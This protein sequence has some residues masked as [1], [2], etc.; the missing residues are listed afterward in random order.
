[1][2]LILCG[3][4]KSGKTT[5]GKALAEVLHCPFVDVD[6]VI[7]RMDGEELSCREICK[8]RGENFF[9]ALEKN[10]L[11]SLQEVQGSVI[12]LGGGSCLETMHNLGTLIYLKVPVDTLWERA[13]QG[14]LP[15]YLDPHFPKESFYALAKK[16]FPLYEKAADLIIDV[17]LE[18]PTP[19]EVILSA[20]S[21]K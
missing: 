4:Q 17:T 11:E 10:A 6:R 5:T 14:E 21:L 20:L 12:A 15:S 19:W 1:M 18:H 7:E 13:L 8:Q 9:R 2:N 16:R 3:M